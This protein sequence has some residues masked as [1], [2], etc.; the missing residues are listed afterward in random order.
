MSAF[1]ASHSPASVVHSVGRRCIPTGTAPRTHVHSVALRSHAS[2]FHGARMMRIASA[3]RMEGRAQRALAV[4]IKNEISYVMIKPDGVQ[5]GLVG[6]IISRFER[7]GFKLRGLKLFQCTRDI[8]EEH[9]KDLSSKP[10]FPA[11]VDYILSG[12]VVAMVWEGDGVVKS[13]RK[14]IGATNPL[15]AEPGTIRG[16]FAVAVGRNVVHGSDS[17]E[18]GER[19]TGLWFNSNELVAWESTMTPWLVE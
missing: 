9:Y 18:N 5:R 17:P 10:F 15:E 8:A 13:A 19:E 14:L 3:S 4:A 1:T 12:P 2:T 11:L 16:D 7:K 6:E